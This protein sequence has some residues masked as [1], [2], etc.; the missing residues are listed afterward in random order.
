MPDNIPASRKFIYSFLIVAIFFGGLELALRA[1]DFQFYFN[2]SADLLGMPLLDLC[3]FRRVANQTVNFDPQVFWKF[4]PN[5]I[6]D[7]KGIYKKPVRINNFG[8]RGKDFQLEKK[9]GTYRII[10]LGDSVT[11]GWSVADEET[12][13]AQLEKILQE[14]YPDRDIEV[15]NLGVTGYTSFQGKKLFLT[16]AEKLKP[17]LVIF[18]FGQN[19]RLP[20]LK[21]DQELFETK[22]WRKNKLDLFLSHSQVYKILKAGVI[23]LQRRQEGLSLDPKTYLPRLKRKVSQEEYQDNFKRIKEECDQLGCKLIL[24]NVDFPSL[25]IDPAN[26]ALKSLEQK[27]NAHLLKNWQEWDSLKLIQKISTESGAKLLDLR[28]VFASYLVELEEGKGDQKRKSEFDQ[29]LGEDV[30]NEPWKYLMIDNGHPNEW[31]H[32]IIAESLANLIEA[33][34]FFNQH[35]EK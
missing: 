6:L 26:S 11:F 10:C 35:K 9:P 31:G 24:L 8:F 22:A 30:K 19:D 18:G 34:A 29:A 15:L 21:S 28:S 23:Y 32:Q 17:D 4:K 33:E 7:A 25:A 12:Y 27:H 2:F 20:A 16:F 5:Q 1:Y 3:K 13:P 14:K